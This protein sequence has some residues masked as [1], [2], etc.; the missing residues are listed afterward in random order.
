M[1]EWS[2]DVGCSPSRTWELIAAQ[3]LDTVKFGA[4]RIILTPPAAFLA[5]L[6]DSIDRDDVDAQPARGVNGA[7]SADQPPGSPEQEN[8]V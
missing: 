3:R 1:R 4:S 7:L 2:A 5:S 8:A 6:H